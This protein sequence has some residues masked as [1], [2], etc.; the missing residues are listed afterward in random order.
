MSYEG[1]YLATLDPATHVLYMFSQHDNRTLWTLNGSWNTALI[2]GTG[3]YVAAGNYSTVSIF[4]KDSNTTLFSV[5]S[6][7][8]Y[9]SDF[10]R[11]GSTIAVI[12]NS[13]T[14]HLYDRV[15]GKEMF[16]SGS[17]GV[18]RAS[19]SSNGSE[20]AAVTPFGGLFVYNRLGSLICGAQQGR[21]ANTFVAISGDGRSVVTGN[22]QLTYMAVV[23]PNQTPYILETVAGIAAAVTPAT[24][25]IFLSIR[26]RRRTGKSTPAVGEPSG[27]RQVT[28]YCTQRRIFHVK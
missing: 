12:T 7:G 25:L 24:F 5:T 28:S 11:D 15:T 9:L 26:R 3:D 21:G 14:L 22:S 18:Y 8:T 20:T 16:S 23:F 4:G 6:P 2:S 17:V 19:V 13:S 27:K 10:S 1:A